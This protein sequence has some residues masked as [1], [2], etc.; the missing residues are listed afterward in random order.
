MTAGGGGRSAGWGR[1]GE[2]GAQHRESRATPPCVY[3]YRCDERCFRMA[4]HLLRNPL[5]QHPEGA[6]LAAH[7]EH[8][9]LQG[10]QKGDQ[11][12]HLRGRG[13]RFGQSISPQKMCCPSPGSR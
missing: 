10:W 7:T 11:G 2:G 4:E 12:E 3:A 5:Q 6:L 13:L 1:T 9:Q 8:V